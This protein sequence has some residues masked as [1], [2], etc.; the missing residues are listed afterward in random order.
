MDA[1]VT[2]ASGHLGSTLVARLVLPFEDG[3]RATMDIIRSRRG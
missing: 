2:G 1:V 3:L